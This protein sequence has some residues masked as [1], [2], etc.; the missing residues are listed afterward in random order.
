MNTKLVRWN[1]TEV[2]LSSFDGF[3]LPGGFSYE[4]RGRSGIIASKDPIFKKILAE[5]DKGKALIGICNGAQMLVELGIIPGVTTQ[6]LDMALAW[7]ERIRDEKILGTG[8]YNDWINIKNS[9]T[10]GRCAFNNFSNNLVLRIPVA[11]GEGRYTTQIP[12]L[13]NEMI[14][15]ERTVFRYCDDSGNFTEG[16][17]TNPNNAIYNLAGICNSD[18]NIMA[19]MPHPERTPIG[20]PIFTSMR[21]YIEQKKYTK[22]EAKKATTVWREKSISHYETTSDYQ[23]RIKLIIT[24]NEERTMEQAFRRI[25]FEDLRLMK[26][27]WVDVTLSE[28]PQTPEAEK[29]LLEAIVRSNVMMNP[30]KETVKITAR[31]GRK[32]TYDTAKGIVADSTEEEIHTQG[33]IVVIDPDNY[34]GKGMAESLRK[35]YPQSNIKNIVKGTLWSIAGSKPLSEIIDTHLLHNPHSTE[36]YSL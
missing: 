2:D 33:G 20:D 4:D 29:T 30:N 15:Q 32:F 13:L 11:H 3:I 28:K 25:G 18:G 9:V 23:F 10:P 19:L 34:S 5:A 21:E 8:F 35:R 31:D 6:K 1:D 14:A 22:I 16:F 12:G 27:V 26:Q 24:D 7:N 36:I 17:P